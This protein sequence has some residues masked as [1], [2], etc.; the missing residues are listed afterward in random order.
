MAASIESRTP[1][2]DYRLVELVL[3]VPEPLLFAPGEP[4]PLLRAA[5][6]GWL[7][8]EVAERRDKRGFPTPLHRWREHPNL[9]ALVECLTTPAHGPREV[10]G[11]EW[12]VSSDHADGRTV[13]ADGYLADREAFAAS[14]LWTVLTVQGWLS[15]LAAGTFARPLER[16]RAA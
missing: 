3:R 4:K 7:P 10:A 14:E 5:V 9:R 1:L 2:L 13:F 16:R 12:Q 11:A 6:A 15:S 8:R